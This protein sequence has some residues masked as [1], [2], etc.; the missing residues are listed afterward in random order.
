MYFEFPNTN[1]RVLGSLHMVPVGS[2]EVP[3]WARNAY[4][5]CESL[6]VEHDPPSLLPL[7]K[8]NGSP[9]CQLQPRIVAALEKFWPSQGPLSPLGEL[10]PWAVL[11]GLA[12]L[13][14]QAVGGIEPNF[15]RWAVEHAKPVRYLETASDVVRSFDSAL[16]EDIEKS[17]EIAL[18]DLPLFQRR[19]I[20]MHSAWLSRDRERLLSVAA[21]AP[22]FSLPSLR[23]AVLE[24]RNRAWAPIVERMLHTS[25]RTL[26]VVGALHLC[27]T[28]S[29][30]QCIGRELL[31]IQSVA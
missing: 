2:D 4:D 19:F 30:D 8:S 10:R 24:N 16:L 23:Q 15:L 20:E 28:G 25:E 31:P 22:L 26:V 18:P 21:S 11:I 9:P 3:S 14:Q 17:I 27:G 6:V 5:W 1:V 29:L 7:F 13:N 12:V